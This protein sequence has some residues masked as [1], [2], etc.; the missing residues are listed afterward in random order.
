MGRCFQ[1]EGGAEEVT[2]Q[3][4]SQDQRF[5]VLPKRQLWDHERGYDHLHSL[6]ILAVAA[7]GRPKKRERDQG[8]WS[9]H[10]RPS[11]MESLLPCYLELRAALLQT[12][13]YACFQAGLTIVSTLFDSLRV[14]E[15][16][17]RARPFLARC[18]AG[19]LAGNRA[20]F[21]L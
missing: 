16:G 7:I 19:Q 20:G 13:C 8:R 17:E 21:S 9:L 18:A 10:S 6:H 14:E 11:T 3:A 2:L 15:A 1:H 5:M 12:S 4:H